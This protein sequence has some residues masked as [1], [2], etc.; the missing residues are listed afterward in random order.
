MKEKM[1]EKEFQL[2]GN[3]LKKVRMLQNVS[4]E[5]LG[6]G[7]Y[8]AVV[9]GRIEQGSFFPER[10][11][12]DRLLER[13]G[14]SSYDYE[15]Y[16]DIEDYKEWE[17]QLFLVDALNRVALCEAEALLQEYEIQY[18][19][20]NIMSKQF[21][22]VMLLQ[23]L[24]LKGEKTKEYDAILE[25][26]VK[27]T[28]PMIDTTPISELVLSVSELNLVLEYVVYQQEKQLKKGFKK[29]AEKKFR[30]KIQKYYQ[31]LFQYI[32]RSYFDLESKALFG[33]KLSLYYCKYQWKQLQ[34]KKEKTEVILLAQ[35]ILKIVTYGIEAIRNHK[36]A[37]FALELLQI[38]QDIL[39]FLLRK[40]ESLDVITIE[41][42]KKEQEETISF[43]EV[44]RR[45]Y[46]TRN[47]PKQTNQYTIFYQKRE[48]YCINDVI[49]ARR[50]MFQV[51]QKSLE[52]IC[53]AK[54]IKR[55]EK[56]EVNPQKETVRRLFQR[57][58]L[59]SE[60]H[61]SF[62][63]TDNQEVLRLEKTYR[64]TINQQ[65]YVEAEELLKKIKEMISMEQLMNK[66]YIEYE[67]VYLRYKT[68][69]IKKEEFIQRAKAILAYTMPLEIIL[70]PLEEKEKTKRWNSKERYF[71]TREL[72]MFFNIAKN[73]EKKEQEQYF[74]ILQQYLEYWE[75][76]VMIAPILG[77]YGLIMVTIASYMAN[78]GKYE[79]A[80]E[81]NRKIIEQSLRLRHLEYVE[82]NMYD[83][84]WN[85]EKKEGFLE[86]ENL[87]RLL[88]MQD[89]IVLD[90]YNR[91]KMN[92]NWMKNH[93]K[94]IFQD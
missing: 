79:E 66:Q 67:E 56:K 36:K 83:L 13:L 10:L 70:Q 38:K 12:R 44:F 88:C 45:L 61:R 4:Q 43:F 25:Q 68:K 64:V 91:E 72:V 89:C 33:S 26:A 20:N 94:K 51:T 48:I 52:N 84:M 58:Y 54:T 60:L 8:S 92:E 57:F 80:I 39:S 7:I 34:Q 46:E 82:G 41:Q 85:E 31:E 74:F 32:E 23:Y 16:I 77:T 30:M 65:N 24:E 27:L 90:V 75:E 6:E 42:Y 1:S 17:A 29:Q 86:K 50:K 21:Y 93:L 40:E 59:S 2:F 22:L 47:I 78:N 76:K 15:A 28:I 63:V 53:S 87:D 69:K 9:I 81:I 71:T 3:L 73:S 55:L 62:L 35:E 37:Y 19:E 14:E 11:I 5:K 49:R 18:K